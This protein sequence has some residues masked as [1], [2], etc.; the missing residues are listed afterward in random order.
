LRAWPQVLLSTRDGPEANMNLTY[1]AASLLVGATSTTSAS[2]KSSSSSPTLL[3]VMIV[4][5]GVLYFFVVRPSSR[6]RMQAMRQVAAYEVGDE[7][8][9]GGMVGRVVRIGDGEVDIDA[10]DGIF[11]FVPSAV[12]SRAAYNASRA[13]AAGARGGFGAR[14]LP[15]GTS[16]G[17]GNIAHDHDENAGPEDDD[18]EDEPQSQDGNGLQSADGGPDSWHW[19][20]AGGQSTELGGPAP[21]GQA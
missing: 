1:R 20:S 10:G 4:V 5:F 3:I 17:Q 8:V 6:R 21:Q 7:V 16:P 9:A 13:R 11:T 15:A 14:G 2:S 12:Q 18:V 19:P